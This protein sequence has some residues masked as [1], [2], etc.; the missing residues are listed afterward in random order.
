MKDEDK[1]EGK[2]GRVSEQ[3]EG[4]KRCRRGRV[5]KVEVGGRWLG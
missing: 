3:R 2:K 1:R 5:G 4:R